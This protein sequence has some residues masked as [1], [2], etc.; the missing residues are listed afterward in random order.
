MER[1][2]FWS[3]FF[4]LRI[5]LIELTGPVGSLGPFVVLFSLRFDLEADIWHLAYS[6]MVNVAYWVSM[7]K[8]AIFPAIWRISCQQWGG[9]TGPFVP[10]KKAAET[11]S[12]LLWSA[13]FMVDKKLP[14]M[15]WRF[16][17]EIYC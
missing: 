12:A 1:Y 10:Q 6:P 2:S 17:C 13:I 15:C 8:I 5:L 11:I 14:I 3:I 4:S 7:R 9:L 16:S